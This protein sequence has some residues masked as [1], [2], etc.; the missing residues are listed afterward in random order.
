MLQLKKET[1]R[2]LVRNIFGSGVYHFHTLG[3]P[4]FSY[5]KIAHNLYGSLEGIEAK[6]FKEATL[7]DGDYKPAK[8]SK[9]HKSWKGN[10]PT[11][12]T[13]MSLDDQ[14]VMTGSGDN[15]SNGHAWGGFYLEDVGELSIVKNKLVV[16]ETE[17][18]GVLKTHY[19]GS[20]SH[21]SRGG[22]TSL[23]YE[24]KVIGDNP[25]D[26]VLAA[27]DLINSELKRTETKLYREL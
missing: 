10:Y 25:S 14:I 9:A 17:L 3:D 5:S 15:S 8:L 21:F 18:N 4:S 27:V 12:E 6:E 11:R 2:R 7:W 24:V 20:V 1:P 13:Y 23:N 19:R 22:H 16:G 26:L